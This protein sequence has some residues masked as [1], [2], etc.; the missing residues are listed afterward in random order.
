MKKRAAASRRRA[1]AARGD[2]I[3]TVAVL[4]ETGTSWG[5]RVVAGVLEYAREHGPWHIDVAPHGPDEPVHV[6]SGWRG[7]GIIARIATRP[8]AKQI[9]ATGA[10]VVN[11]SSVR[12][13]G[14]DWHRVMTE[15]AAAARLAAETFLARGF[16]HFGYV[17]NPA[18]DY[19]QL[20]FRA[21]ADLLAA[22]RRSC[23][24]FQPTGDKVDTVAWL[25]R[26]RK[27]VAIFCWGP[28]IGR[29]VIDACLSAGITVPHDVAVLGGDFDDIFS[30][31]SY[32]AQSGIQTAAEQIGLTAAAV[33][34]RIM[35]GDPP[36]RRE[37]PVPPLGVVEKLSTDTLAVSDARLAA[38]MRFIAEH[39]A[40]PVTVKSILRENPMARRSLERKFRQQFGCTIVEH[41]RRIRLNQARLLLATT[42]HPMTLIA[43]KCGFATYNYMSRIFRTATGLSPQQY[44]SRCR[45]TRL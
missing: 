38:V 17:G 40:E 13:E 4:V 8:A 24:F 23:A 22:D 41:I 34:D 7:D 28:L 43:E 18:K 26:L 30:E 20:Q 27:P 5:R 29:E 37:W 11:V 6:P 21:F 14:V 45:A 10:A 12:L 33:L 2:G 31:A 25:R 35:R 19:V 32:P 16:P 36:A 39:A 15:P 44:R 42:D 3:P 9:E 1:R